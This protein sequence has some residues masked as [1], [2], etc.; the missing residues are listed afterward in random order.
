VRLP[1]ALFKHQAKVFEV[2]TE[3]IE[4]EDYS[5]FREWS[6]IPLTGETLA[7]PY[8]S[9]GLMDGYF[10]LEAGFVHPDGSVVKT[11]LDLSLPERIIEHHFLVEGGELMMRRGTRPLGGKI[12]PAIAIEKFGNYQQYYFKQHP[13]FGLRVLQDGTTRALQPEQIANDLGC[14]LRDEKRYAEAIQAFTVAIDGNNAISYLTFADRAR[15]YDELGE[16]VQAEKDWETVR[17]LANQ[18]VVDLMRLK[19]V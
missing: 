7:A 16:D 9:S 19:T 11:Y 8:T 6:V 3:F 2:T 4:D 10:V 13:E 15:L 14:V 5:E 1:D 17:Q 18:E 12:I